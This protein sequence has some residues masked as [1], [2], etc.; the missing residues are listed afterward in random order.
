MR[1]CDPRIEVWEEKGALARNG[2]KKASG[3]DY[4]FDFGVRAIAAGSAR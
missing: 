4:V 1:Y 3:K 2:N